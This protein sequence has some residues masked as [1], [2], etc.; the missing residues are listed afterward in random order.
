MILYEFS[1]NIQTVIPCGL[2][3][4]SQLKV[5]RYSQNPGIQIRESPSNGEA[6]KQRSYLTTWYRHSLTEF[7]N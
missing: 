3:L 5:L 1:N 6:N 7:L 2:T 4:Q